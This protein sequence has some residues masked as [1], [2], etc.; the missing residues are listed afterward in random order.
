MQPPAVARTLSI[1]RLRVHR[2]SSH[3]PRNTERLPRPSVTH[4]CSSS[5]IQCISPT[6]RHAIDACRHQHREPHDRARAW[7]GTPPQPPRHVRARAHPCELRLL[8]SEVRGSDFRDVDRGWPASPGS[9]PLVRSATGP[10]EVASRSELSG[11][12]RA[13][14]PQNSAVDDRRRNRN[15]QAK[16]SMPVDR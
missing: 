13:G 10:K 9:A 3:C 12:E 5:M 6:T 2:P 7:C 14:S 11:R 15:T 4:A 8:F 16:R 1:Q